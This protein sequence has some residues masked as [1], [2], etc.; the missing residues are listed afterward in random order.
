MIKIIPFNYWVVCDYYHLV[1]SDN[2][3]EPQILTLSNEQLVGKNFE[4][5]YQIIG[6]FWAFGN[7]RDMRDI[8]DMLYG[9]TCFCI[10]LI[11]S[12]YK[13]KYNKYQV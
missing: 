1:N 10:L 4:F 7:M 5:R 3:F 2:A 11:Y 9:G 13:T 8:C 6:I 12:I